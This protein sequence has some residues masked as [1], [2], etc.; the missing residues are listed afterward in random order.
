MLRD[1]GM[2]LAW[3]G[4]DVDLIPY[5]QTLSQADLE[6]ARVVFLLPTMDF[7]GPHNETWSDAELA[8][9][10]NYVAQGGFL[11][12]TNSNYNY[13]MMRRLEDS[14]EDARD[15]NTLLEPMGIRFTYGDTG[16]DIVRAVTEH[17]LMSEA[18]Y[19]TQFGWNGVPIR[20]NSGLV[21]ARS[22]GNAV[23]GLLDYGNLGGQVLVV[24]DLGLL[25]ADDDA[26]NMNFIQNLAH[27][28][29]WRK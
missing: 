15:L 22:G 17:P 25:Q 4:F 28:A 18:G 8:L 16:E 6:N 2:A 1:L 10:E 12:V 5:G 11:V 21:L 3:E 29:R 24:A 27:F 9:L 19:L 14:N 13:V 26:R 20:M 7:P 23:I